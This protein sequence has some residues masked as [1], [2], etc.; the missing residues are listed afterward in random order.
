MAECGYCGK[1]CAGKYCSG[2]SCKNAAW[3]NR[4]KLM[5]YMV[6]MGAITDAQIRVFVETVDAVRSMAGRP[7]NEA[8]EAGDVAIDLSGR[9]GK[10]AREA[11][12]EAGNVQD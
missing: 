11:Q 1:P 6:E 4:R 5:A 10:G 8:T 12:R 7:C 3:A 2:N 9:L